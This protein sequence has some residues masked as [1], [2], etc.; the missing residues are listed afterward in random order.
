MT[1]E[2]QIVPEL[3]GVLVTLKS[4]RRSRNSK[5]THPA[6]VDAVHAVDQKRFLQS[7]TDVMCFIDGAAEF[8]CDALIVV[9]QVK[10]G[11]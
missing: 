11:D 2:L 3:Q 9:V 10:D 5:A 8:S 1:G 6:Y 7:H 4:L